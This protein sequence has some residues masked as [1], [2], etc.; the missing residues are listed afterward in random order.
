MGALLH[1]GYGIAKHAPLLAL[2]K[3]HGH[4]LSWGLGDAYYML[5]N[6]GA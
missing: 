3:V 4:E 2:K 6:A 1:N 5:Q